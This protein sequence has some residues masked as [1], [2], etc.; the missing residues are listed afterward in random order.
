MLKKGFYCALG[1]PLD[2]EGNL[3]KRSLEAHIENQISAGASGLLLMGTM[4]MLGCIRNGKYEEIVKTA[5]NAVNKRVPLMVGAAD[6]SIARVRDRV[7]IL[8]N[9]DVKVVVTAPYYFAITKQTA[10]TYFKAVSDMTKHDIILYDHPYTSRYKLD[11]FDVM[12][13]SKIGNM[14]GI[15]TGD[16]ILI[17]TLHDTKEL[18]E[19]FTPVFSNSD[20]FAVGYAYGIEHIL[21]GIFACF[22]KLIK[23]VQDAFNKGDFESGKKA[24]NR[25]MQGRD[26]MTAIGIWPA[27]TYAMN[28]LGFEGNFSPDYEPE[29][30]ADQ[31]S[32]VKT[33]MAD[34]GEIDG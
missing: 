25:L 1:T 5:V 31:K 10:M 3:I 21:D 27:F 14:K 6:N 12:E 32:A 22:P 13:L 19:D 2:R 26:D 20:L 23:R 8:N 9:Y 24:L 4:G 11:Y 34:T 17:K 7:D 33:I 18:K 16:M 29:L 28:L 30:T 15:K